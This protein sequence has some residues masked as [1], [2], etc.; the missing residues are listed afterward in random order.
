MLTVIISLMINYL[1][2][3][4]K[5][6]KRYKD[7]KLLYSIGMSKRNIKKLVKN[8]I[9]IIAIFGI[10]FGVILGFFGASYSID[11]L[12]STL[13]KIIYNEDAIITANQNISHNMNFDIKLLIAIIISIYIILIISSKMALKNARKQCNV[14]VY[15][16]IKR[17]NIKSPFFVNLLLGI[18]GKMAYRNVKYIKSKYKMLV[19]L[20]TLSLVLLF[21][22]NGFINNLYINCK[23]PEEGKFND[24][25]ITAYTKDYNDLIKNKLKNENYYTA[26]NL[27][28]GK[29]N[30]KNDEIS[31]TIKQMINDKVYKKNQDESANIKVIGYQLNGKVYEEILKRVGLRELKDNETIIINAMSSNNKYG[32]KI[33][34]TN[35]KVGDSYTFEYD[36]IDKKTNTTKKGEKNFKIAGILEEFDDY[37]SN[38]FNKPELYNEHPKIIQI[39]NEKV[40]LELAENPDIV[41]IYIDTENTDTMEEYVKELQKECTNHFIIGT[42]IKEVRESEQA[43]LDIMKIVL[44]SFAGVFCLVS[45][46]NTYNAISTSSFLRKKDIEILKSMGISKIKMFKMYFWEGIFYSIDAIVYSLVI[47]IFVLFVLYFAMLDTSL[48]VL[49]IELNQIIIGAVSLLTVVYLSMIKE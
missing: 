20:N 22:V 31:D 19:T 37:I 8:E 24:Y 33:K 16:N 39:T 11:Y 14:N 36:Y 44:Y 1:L 42:N 6:Q 9:R 7:Y 4:N 13:N 48:Y 12:N 3:K 29:I 47:S 5:Y 41:T 35:Y 49:Q 30:L 10:I 23:M 38:I 32:E 40:G 45:I 25:K 17:R 28:Q 2:L 18:Q 26:N 46:L 34:V 15:T 27:T 43:K 21:T